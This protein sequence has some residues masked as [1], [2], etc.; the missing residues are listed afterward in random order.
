M[1]D[2]TEAYMTWA[3]KEDGDNTSLHVE[4][5]DVQSTY[6]IRVVDVFGGC[7]AF[8]IFFHSLIILDVRPCNATILSS[9]R[10]IAASLIRQGYLPCSPLKPTVA[11]T[12]RAVNLY[13][14]SHL[15]CPHVSV[16]SFVKTLCDIHGVP[17][18]RWLSRQFSIAYDLLLDIR[19]NV[20][21]L[22][23]DA[24][25]RNIPNW[26]LCNACPACTYKLE[27][28]GELKF[29][30]LFT[31]DGND[32]LKQIVRRDVPIDGDEG[33]GQVV[34]LPDSRTLDS[35]YYLTRASVDKWKDAVNPSEGFQVFGFLSLVCDVLIT[36]LGRFG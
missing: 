10:T 7:I 24:L 11:I 32:S 28:E 27:E 17:F 15:R 34:E 26:R 23:Q 22:V 4:G 36:S 6:A 31:M 3:S 29:D 21:G 30:M 9:D 8:F 18:Q 33:P 1:T 20:D 35:D 19:R 13:R 14:L 16:Q 5:E 25:R 2:L 12:I